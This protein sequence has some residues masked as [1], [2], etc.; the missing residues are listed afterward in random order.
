[1]ARGSLCVIHRRRRHSSRDVTTNQGRPPLGHKAAKAKAPTPGLF[2]E[3]S[4]AAYEP[5]ELSLNL[6]PI[7]SENA[8][9]VTRI[10]SV[11]S[12][13][14]A[15]AAKPFQSCLFVIDEGDHDLTSLCMLR[16]AG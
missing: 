5:D 4:I 13:G 12:N 11:E 9:L 14:I 6:D 2:R 10:C 8:R 16:L 7:R 1:M 15:L 3:F